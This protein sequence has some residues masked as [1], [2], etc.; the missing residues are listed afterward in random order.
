MN[1]TR[2]LIALLLAA[3][4]LAPAPAQP[5]AEPPAPPAA[6]TDYVSREDKSFAWKLA[7]KTVTDAGTVYTI[8][9]VSQTW[10]DIKWEHKLQVIVP[11]G[12][13]P[14]KSMMLWNQGGRPGPTSALLGLE[15][16]KRVGAPVAFL[17][18]VPNQ[19]LFGG[20]T[21]DALIAETFVRYLDTK[22]A[23]W[24][25]LFPMVKSVIRAMDALQAF[26]REHLGVELTGFV[27]TGASKRG[28]TSWLT[29]ATGDPRVKAIAPLVI[30]TLNFPVQVR[31][32]LAAFGRPSEMVKDYTNRGLIPIP[33]TPE[34]T[35]LW[36]M[37][38][39]WVYRSRVRVPK[40]IINGTNDPYWPLDA[41]NTYW[42]DLQGE[43]YLLYVPNAGHDL[44]E[45]DKDG[46][47]E[48]LPQRAVNALSA[49]TKAKV[50]GKAMPA[51]TWKEVAPAATTLAVGFESD[52]KMKGVRLW[53]ATAPTRDF[54][55]ARWESAPP[56]GMIWT[57][58]EATFAVPESG[59]LKA[60][61][62]EAEYELDGQPFSLTTQLRILEPK[63]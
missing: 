15:M 46:R 22:D 62:V 39:P 26:A 54:R 25:L 23:T 45:T 50:F 33:N 16:A 59:S 32:Q 2:A 35:Q 36:Q 19:P 27:V 4:A 61:F 41:L 9:L 20:K 42:D 48:L 31:N 3:L 34:A 52:T 8:D 7:D 24:P 17:F 11:A 12:M 47:K 18:G 63:K 10:H 60:G 5:K 58:G 55:K 37:V 57:K 29:A 1:V 28:W 38:D 30:D 49:F 13:N 53:G 51:L 6:L 14:Q 43:K 40:L 21:E 56:A 44:R